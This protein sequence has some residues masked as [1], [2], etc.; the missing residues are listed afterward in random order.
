MLKIIKIVESLMS[1]VSQG[2][3]RQGGK[4]IGFNGQ[5]LAVTQDFVKHFFSTKIIIF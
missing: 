3:S 2:T 1:R 5:F 4:I